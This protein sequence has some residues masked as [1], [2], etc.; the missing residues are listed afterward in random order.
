M[1][2]RSS[3]LFSFSQLKAALGWRRSSTHSA[4]ISAG[5]VRRLFLL[6]SIM[7]RTAGRREPILHAPVAD[8]YKVANQFFTLTFESVEGAVLKTSTLEI[9]LPAP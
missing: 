7:R 2:M 6:S 8:C 1:N 4:A 9:R 3:F 5:L